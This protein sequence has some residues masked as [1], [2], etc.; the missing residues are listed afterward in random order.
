MV[1]RILGT[2]WLVLAVY[3]DRLTAWESMLVDSKLKRWLSRE[4]MRKGRLSIE[5]MRKRWLSRESVRK[6]RLARESIPE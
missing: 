4:P 6:G 2:N 3:T 1:R 5:S